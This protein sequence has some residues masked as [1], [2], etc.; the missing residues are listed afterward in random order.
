[1]TGTTQ[2]RENELKDIM[3]RVEL[4]VEDKQKLMDEAVAEV[5]A[6]H[7]DFLEAFKMP[8]KAFRGMY[9]VHI[10]FNMIDSLVEKK[11]LDVTNKRIQ[12]Y[13]D[14]QNAKKRKV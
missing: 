11:V 14:E 9:T 8:L 2:K 1:M 7:A 3:K 10:L 4:S 5:H 13:L 12:A 6:Q